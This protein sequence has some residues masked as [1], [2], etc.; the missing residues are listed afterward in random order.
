MKEK[1]DGSRMPYRTDWEEAAQWS[2]AK[3][4]ALHWREWGFIRVDETDYQKTRRI[5]AEKRICELDRRIVVGS[6][7][8]HDAVVLVK[9]LLRVTR[10]PSK[11]PVYLKWLEGKEHA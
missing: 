6:I 11:R 4:K 7:S 9:E 2:Y 3:E 1:V 5:E 8:Q 10:S